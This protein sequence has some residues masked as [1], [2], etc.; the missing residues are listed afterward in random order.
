MGNEIL[1]SITSLGL[2]QHCLIELYAII[3]NIYQKLNLKN[4]FVVTLA[5]LKVLSSHL[6]LVAAILD[7]AGLD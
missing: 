1:Q 5:I 7:S 2:D 4:L 3:L 6:W